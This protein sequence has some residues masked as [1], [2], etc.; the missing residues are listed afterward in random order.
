MTGGGLA[1]L[2][3]PVIPLLRDTPPRALYIHYPF[4]AH[5]CHYCDFS[6][7]RAAVP[8]ADEWIDCLACELPWWFETAGWAAPLALDSVFIGGGTPSLMDP[9]VPGA[10]ADVLGVWFG[11]EEDVEWTVESNPAS[12]TDEVATAWRAAGANRLSIGVQSFDDEVLSWLGRL[13]DRATA[14]AAV[15]TARRAGFD[16]INLDLMFGLPEAIRRDLDTELE[17]LIDTGVDHV[18]AYGL[19]IEPD[20][21][22]ARQV[23]LGRVVPTGGSAY[24]HEYRTIAARLEAAGMRHYEVSNFA[25]DGRECRHNWY[26]WNRSPYLGIGPSAHGYLPP[27]RI[28]NAFRWSRYRDVVRAGA[29]AVDGYE[30]LGPAEEPL[31]RL[32]LGLR[33]REGLVRDD[34][35][36]GAVLSAR[37]DEW[38]RLGWVRTTGGRVVATAEGWLRL[39]ELVTRLATEEA[40]MENRSRRDE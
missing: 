15:R 1:G 18:S 8:P 25:S 38:E 23:T 29:G 12:L 17:I 11:L 37:A 21:P 14:E 30:S 7:T 34:P 28:W 2:A 16:N 13:H 32:W 26:Y 9:D 31:E 27:L 22:L 20:T 3:A 40:S 19:T 36:W 33:T 24:G 10:L 39:D 4:C 35:E 5:R 6:V